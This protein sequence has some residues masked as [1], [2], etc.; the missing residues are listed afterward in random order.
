MGSNVA[1]TVHLSAAAFAAAYYFL[2]WN[3]TRL[4]ALFL[5]DFNTALRFKASPRIRYHED[6]RY[7][8][9][10]DAF[11]YKPRNQTTDMFSGNND[12]RNYAQREKD[13]RLEVELADEADRILRKISQTGRDSL[14]RAE[15][16]ALQAYSELLQRK[17][18]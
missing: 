9:E 4:G 18:R 10:E 5:G 13:A 14:T 16:R 17:K 8:D 6:E 11:L 15:E 12:S 1:Y 3:F 2:N 7:D